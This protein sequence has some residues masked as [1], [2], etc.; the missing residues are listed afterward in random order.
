LKRASLLI[1]AV[2]WVLSLSAV[3]VHHS[4]S[5]LLPQ[6]VHVRWSEAASRDE[7]IQVEHEL[8]LASGEQERGRTWSYVLRDVSTTNIG[9]LVRHPFVED[10]HYIDRA[11]ATLSVDLLARPGW[12]R[13]LAQTSVVQI[14]VRWLPAMALLLAFVGVAGVWPI[15]RA[16]A[17][18]L[19]HT[20]RRLSTMSGVVLRRTRLS[21]YATRRQVWDAQGRLSC[22]GTAAVQLLLIAYAS[23]VLRIVLVLSGGQFY[24]GDETR[25][26]IARDIARTLSHGE[27]LYAFSRM[28]QHP[29]FGVVGAVPAVIEQITHQDVR[30][31]GIFFAAFSVVN[32]GLLALIAKRSGASDGESVAAGGLLALSTSMLY[33]ARH[34]LPYDVAMTFGL[35]AVFVGIGRGTRAASVLCGVLAACAFLTYTGYWTLGGA[36]MVV[37][38]LVADSRRAGVRRAVFS[39]LGLT[40]MIGAVVVGS[41]AVGENLLRALTEFSHQVDQGDFREGW[42]LPWEYLWHAEHVILLMWLLAMAW[43]IAR[44]RS[45]D[46]PRGARVGLIGVAFLYGS[47]TVMSVVTHTFVVYGRLARQLV[48]FLCLITAAAL[49]RA[50][51]S[52]SPRARVRFACVVALVLLVQAGLNFKTPLRQVFPAEFLRDARYVGLPGDGDLVAINAKRLYPGPDA[53]T[54]PLHYTVLRRAPHPLQYLPY[55]YEGYPPSQRSAL[56]S[57][58]IEMKLLLVVK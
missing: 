12:A 48:P 41:L 18:A 21:W 8:G 28:G 30:I 10:T 54:L 13:W 5:R 58:D 22:R 14:S 42:L 49:S 53:V 55:Q 1:A 25:Y 27:F 35:L 50:V 32:V 43:T 36:A 19:R 4:V 56:R 40:G 2:A 47:L 45:P 20:Q 15:W 38:V 7:R 44:L 11:T 37:H 6:R 52:L 24:W 39:A 51:L 33:Y 34:L 23:M 16:L 46:L 31:P 9:R 26:E 29:L 57:A 3:I 17:S